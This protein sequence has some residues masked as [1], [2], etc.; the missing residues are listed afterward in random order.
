MR[1]NAWFSLT[2]RIGQ[3]G[4]LLQQSA[5]GLA[6]LGERLLAPVLVNVATV[7]G[8][9]RALVVGGVLSFLFAL[10]GLVQ[11]AHVARTEARLY[12]RVVDSALR[13][14]VLQP[15]V[16][17]DEEARGVLFEGAHTVASL[18][19][20]G[21]P[22]L[23]A[24][25]VASAAFSVFVALTQP[26]RIVAV[27][28][29]SG[30]LGM[31]LL[32]ASRRAIEA[33]QRAES[34]AWVQL[35][36]A[37]GSAFDGRLEIVAGGRADSYVRTFAG[38]VSS[39]RMAT[40]RT[41]R[42]ARLAGRLPLLALAMCVGAAVVLDSLLRGEAAGRTLAQATLLASMSPAF[43][44]VA[45]G[46]QEIAKSSRRMRQMLALLGA[47]R[48]P[49]QRG[50]L[51]SAD[52]RAVELRDVH[53]SYELDG[54]RHEA[55]SG[56]SFSWHAGELLA[57]AGPNGSGKSTCLRVLLG[58]G[59]PS[60]GDVFIGGISLERIDL[61]R[62]RH[63]IAFLPQRPYL[64]PRATVRECL[65]FI[66]ADLTDAAMTEAAE[67]ADLGRVLGR[68]A[69]STL[70][71]R[72]DELSVGQRQ[73]VGLTRLLCR[74]A[75]IIMLDEPDANLDLAGIEL[76]SELIRELARDR[77]VIVAAHSPK[78]LAAADRVV[79]L[80]SGR[81]SSESRRSASA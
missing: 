80:D 19:A 29:L 61:D 73:R 54:R 22:N 34:T 21:V 18:L 77:L 64:P 32:A 71:V 56:V 47:D 20:E 48:S 46:V 68:E 65:R 37:V 12:V 78:I 4:D 28:A 81:I 76:A 39:W 14:D 13:R 50:T 42:A 58:L 38:I 23:G 26:S 35:V 44:G 45:Q 55:L 33:A 63:R 40:L 60:A 11:G 30:G 2:R 15:S 8:A 62:W 25:I 67:R 16:L 49:V 41:G 66:D 36:D 79:T 53:F 75:P 24:N 27:A 72:V 5:V 6:V 74:R 9:G 7:A 70:D 52:V 69:R 10:R 17:P 51:V 57:L 1:L 31:V 43:V 59:K 3:R